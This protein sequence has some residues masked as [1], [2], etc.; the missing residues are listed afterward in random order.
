M[1][2]R[3]AEMDA[4]VG[5]GGEVTAVA[6]FAVKADESAAVRALSY[7]VPEVGAV[8]AFNVGATKCARRDPS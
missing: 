8:H 5:L 1:A 7:P 6:A 3:Y 4:T 2:G